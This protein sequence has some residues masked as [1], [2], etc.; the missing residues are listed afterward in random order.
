MIGIISGLIGLAFGLFWLF[1]GSNAVHGPAATV[2]AVAGCLIFALAALWIVLRRRRTRGRR[3]AAGYYLAAVGAEVVAIV[4]A[5][6]WLAAHGQKQLLF[7]VV[8]IIVGLHFI[9]L[10]LATGDRVFAW[11]TSAMVAI[12]LAALLLP[13]NPDAR[14]MVSGFGS[15]AALLVAVAA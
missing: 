5:Q 11:L 2:I 1:V 10:W 4:A 13:L 3:F 12:N 14:R 15:S 6:N 8:G 7:P 9:G